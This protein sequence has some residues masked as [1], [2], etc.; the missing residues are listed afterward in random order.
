MIITKKP[1][2][3]DIVVLKLCTSEEVVGKLVIATPTTLTLSKVL[4]AHTIQTDGGIG[5]VFGPFI[6]SAKHDAQMTFNRTTLVTDMLT[7]DEDCAKQYLKLTT[8]L[9]IV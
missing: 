3:N 4:T 7:P 2:V 5:T 9:E 1:E 6:P 8:G